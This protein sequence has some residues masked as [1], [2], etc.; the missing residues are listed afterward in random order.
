M[1]LP[2]TTD[3]FTLDVPYLGGPL[4]I[5]GASS[6]IDGTSLDVPYLGGP[7]WCITPIVVVTGYN[8]IFF[9]TGF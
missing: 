9:G 5:V 2:T 6:S 8:S 4:V 1:A 3:Q 7:F